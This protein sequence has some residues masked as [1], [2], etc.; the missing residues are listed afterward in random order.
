MDEAPPPLPRPL[1]PIPTLKLEPYIFDMQIYNS[2]SFISTLAAFSVFKPSSA[3]PNDTYDFIKQLFNFDSLHR[4]I[5][6]INQS[7][8]LQDI[9]LLGFYNDF[10]NALNS[11]DT[12]LAPI[13]CSLRNKMKLNDNSKKHLKEVNISENP[14]VKA[15]LA[16]MPSSKIENQVLKFIF[17]CAC[18]KP[19]TRNVIMR[20]Y[21]LSF[22][23]TSVFNDSV[24]ANKIQLD[25]TLSNDADRERNQKII[26]SFFVKVG[27]FEVIPYIF[28]FTYTSPSERTYTFSTCGET[29]LLNLLN[30]CL[31]DRKG[32]FHMQETFSEP[33]K[34]FYRVYNTMK[35]QLAN[36]G[37]T[38]KA[39]LD[40]VSNCPD[41]DIYF[42]GGD[43]EPNKKNIEYVLQFILNQPPNMDLIEIIQDITPDVEIEIIE[44]NKNIFKIL[45]D[46]K[47]EVYFTA[48]HAE[49]NTKEFGP[50]K[51]TIHFDDEDCHGLYSIFSQMEYDN[52]DFTQ[53]LSLSI[54]YYLYQ[55]EEKKKESNPTVDFFLTSIKYLILHG[56]MSFPSSID[57]LINLES[58]YVSFE[59][60]P[61]SF[62]AFPDSIQSLVKLTSFITNGGLP[63]PNWIGKLRNLKQLNFTKGN[64]TSLPD[65]LQDLHQ[66]QELYLSNNAFE[67]LPDWIG[68][69]SSLSILDLANN[70]LK[71]LPESI[72]NL[73][74]LKSLDLD[75]NQ[76]TTLPESFQDLT[77]L[78]YLILQNN[79][80]TSLPE[81]IRNL[82]QLTSLNVAYNKLKALPETI[83]KLTSLKG[84]YADDNQLKSLPESLGDLKSLE[85]LQLEYNQLTSLPESIG[86][87]R[88]LK[89]MDV[90]YNELT[91][92]PDS[93]G[94]LGNLKTLYI[95]YNQLTSLP[96]SIGF[97]EN[98]MKL[99]ASG[100]RLTFIPTSMGRLT[101]LKEL[102]LD[103]NQITSVP[104]SVVD[105]P[106]LKKLSLLD[107]PLTSIP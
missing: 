70:K 80:L 66:L 30:Y 53:E 81:W 96:N 87:L 99:K 95:L 62:T 75:S 46:H 85:D 7:T 36:Q 42:S 13:K 23:K 44:D 74:M 98:L 105:L 2:K 32:T 83:G 91:S 35:T 104:E 4:N 10:E 51:N 16:K 37:E 17:Y 89:I 24:H 63:I 107:N 49:M 48:G 33:L 45:L 15:F 39:W 56:P 101:F 18:I 14:A 57:K 73:K 8:A 54:Q 71:S 21:L 59:N 92:L 28:N 58:I 20:H 94:L 25:Y 64:L 11:L 97:L 5:I 1:L 22:I 100:N 103:S 34:E 47:L 76:L 78:T 72:G 84:L 40:V 106:Y 61:P 6:Y 26:N 86:H 69:L 31:I 60:E 3:P 12:A 41:D 65:S 90:S 82:D 55:E 52:R 93:I 29:T 67:T 88:M 38:T 50:S 43:I 27:S 79:Q 19:T 77:S 68:K 102:V 9:I